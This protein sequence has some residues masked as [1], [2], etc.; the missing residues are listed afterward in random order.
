MGEPHQVGIGAW[1]HHETVAFLDCADSLGK[2]RKFLRLDLLDP[3]AEAAR[4][5]KVPR[6]IERGASAGRPSAAILHVMSEA[7][8]GRFSRSALLPRTMTCAENGLPISRSMLM[9]AIH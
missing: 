4:H 8:R 7:R 2:G 1:G 6:M 3:S 5:A 9:Q